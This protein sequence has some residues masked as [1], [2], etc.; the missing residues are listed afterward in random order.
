VVYGVVALSGALDELASGSEGPD[1]EGPWHV[2][3]LQNTESKI[4]LKNTRAPS[5]QSEDATPHLLPQDRAFTPFICRWCRN[6]DFLHLLEI[7]N[8]SKQQ[9]KF[10]AI[11]PFNSSCSC[12]FNDTILSS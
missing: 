4:N 2:T 3:Y 7:T 10:G 6:S 11:P 8:T 12:E 9:H 1:G 5:I